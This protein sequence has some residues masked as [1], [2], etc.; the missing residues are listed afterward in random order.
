MIRRIA[1][2]ALLAAAL[3]PLSSAQG[4]LAAAFASQVRTD[5]AVLAS[6][7]ALATWQKSHAGKLELAH[8]ET[9]KDPYQED[10]LRLDR[11]CAASV[12]ESPAQVVRAAL[13]YVPA[14]ANGALPPLPEKEDAT[15]TRA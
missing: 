2:F 7:P 14:V 3:A 9:D 12:G 11:W 5:V 4:E 8:Y 13:F 6:Q 1:L 10:F 15:L